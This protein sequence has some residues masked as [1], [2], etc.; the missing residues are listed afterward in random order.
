VLQKEMR[1]DLGD[2][3]VKIACMAKNNQNSAEYRDRFIW[4]QALSEACPFMA[5][6]SWKHEVYHCNLCGG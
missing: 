4:E 5:L 1:K 2:D 6:F 3:C